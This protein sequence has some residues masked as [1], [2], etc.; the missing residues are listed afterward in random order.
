MLGPSV[1]FFHY[2]TQLN[3]NIGDIST[4]NQ[5]IICGRR[6]DKCH[7]KSRGSGGGDAWWNI[8]WMCRTLHVK[9]HK[10]G[11]R[12]MSRKYPII[13]EALRERGWSF[14][15]WGKIIHG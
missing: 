5:C 8:L 10:M 11:W 6:A 14:T 4:P 7:I 13:A 2:Q 15:G 3:G 12:T 9:Q 1:N